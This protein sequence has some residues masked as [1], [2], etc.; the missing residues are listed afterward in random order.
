MNETIIIV[1]AG[2]SSLRFSL[3]NDAIIFTRVLGDE[4]ASSAHPHQRHQRGV[5][6]A[7]S[8]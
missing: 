4:P 7:R 8:P 3:F 1:E 6:P 2:S 5:G